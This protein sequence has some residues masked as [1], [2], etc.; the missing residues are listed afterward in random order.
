MPRSV[1]VHPWFHFLAFFLNSAVG[2]LADPGEVLLFFIPDPEPRIF[3]L[4]AFGLFA[5]IFVPLDFDALAQDI[6]RRKG[7]DVDPHAVVEVGITA[8]NIGR[9][10]S[11]SSFSTASSIRRR[12]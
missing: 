10:A 2:F 6:R 5:A 9:T 8:R 11:N 7:T 12:W 3:P 1:R 4:V